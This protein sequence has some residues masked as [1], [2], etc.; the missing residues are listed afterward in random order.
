MVISKGSTP[1]LFFEN[2]YIYD[3]KGNSKKGHDEKITENI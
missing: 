2:Q 3:S 1:S